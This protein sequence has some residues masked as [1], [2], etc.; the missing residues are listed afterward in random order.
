MSSRKNIAIL[1]DLERNEKSGGHVKFWERI[2]QSLVKK[3]LNV[4]LVLFFLGK[5]SKIIKVSESIKFHI[6]KPGFSS[7]NLNFLGIDADSTDLSPINLRLLFELRNFNL[8][9]S[10][11]Q[12]HCMAKTAKLASKIWR[13][14]LTTSYHTDTPSYTEYYILKILKKLPNSLDKLLIKK[15][16]I[17]KKISNSQKEK[18]N[19][20]IESCKFA[21]VN[22]DFSNKQMSFFKNNKIKISK[23]TRG[24]DKNIFFK[25]KINKN[26]F[27]NKYKIN[28]NNKLIFFCGSI[29][30]LK[31]AILLS[32]INKILLDEGCNVT[33]VMAG[34]NIHGEDC[35]KIC[36]KNLLILDYVN[37]SEISKFYNI[38]DL[39]VFPSIY[40]TGP[41]VILEARACG[42]VCIVSKEGGGKRIKKNGEDGVILNNQSPENWS[43]KIIKLLRNKK[44]IKFM[45]EK[46]QLSNNYPSWEDIFYDVFFEKWKSII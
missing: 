25:Q 19:K 12:L 30:K 15:L 28:P 33:T 20:Y 5:E 40:E 16:R 44:K 29:H 31:G 43:G 38:C 37:Q 34:E 3:K 8:I 22:D 24:I 17:H 14:P 35:L 27:F 7:A 26:Y 4:N 46:V 1:I 11:D 41:Q 9:H 18:I 13:I 21:F 6:Y 42:A 36:K 2:S 10:T 39:F 32:K 23:I 45:R